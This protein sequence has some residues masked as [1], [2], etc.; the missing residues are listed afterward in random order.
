MVLVLNT[1]NTSTENNEQPKKCG[2]VPTMK[3]GFFFDLIDYYIFAS[4]IYRYTHSFDFRSVR[5]NQIVL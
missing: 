2:L 4:K 3:Y 5:Q 1:S